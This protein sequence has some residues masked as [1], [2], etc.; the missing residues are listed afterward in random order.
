MKSQYH[1]VGIP[2]EEPRPNEEYLE[3]YKVY[4]SGFDTSPFGVE[5]MRFKPDSPLPEIVRTVPHVAFEV[6][7][8]EAAI[9]GHEVLIEP[10]SPSAGVRVAFI[11]HNGA[12]IEFLEMR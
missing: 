5:W 2:T 3:E 8:L 10:N 12:P 4:V 9:V 7:D 6:D 1:H 11:L